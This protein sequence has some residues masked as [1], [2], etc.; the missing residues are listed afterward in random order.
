MVS[1]TDG[2][3]Q[4]EVCVCASDQWEAREACVSLKVTPAPV[5]SM[6]CVA[7]SE[8]RVTSLW[9]MEAALQ[10]T[11]LQSSHNEQKGWRGDQMHYLLLLLMSGTKQWIKLS[12][13]SPN[14]IISVQINQATNRNPHLPPLKSIHVF[15]HQ[16]KTAYCENPECMSLALVSSAS[17]AIQWPTP[18]TMP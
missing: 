1:I 13:P 8:A 11:A 12:S 5:A 18:I 15:L 2:N 9:P 3:N 7:Q 17:T 6:W 16:N 4:S 10:I 14:V